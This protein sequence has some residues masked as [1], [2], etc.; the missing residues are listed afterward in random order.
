MAPQKTRT[1]LLTCAAEGADGLRPS[2]PTVVS[3]LTPD[4][5][6]LLSIAGCQSRTL[7][8]KQGQTVRRMDERDERDE[9]DGVSDGEEHLQDPDCPVETFSAGCHGIKSSSCVSEPLAVLVRWSPSGRP[10]PGAL[11]PPDAFG[12]GNLYR[13][14]PWEVTALV[15]RTVVLVEG[16]SDRLALERL[17]ER[18]GCDLEASGVRVVDVGGVTNFRANLVRYGPH[19]EGLR[20]AGLCDEGEG[21]IVLRALQDSGVGGT[22]TLDTMAGAGFFICQGELED[23]LLRAVGI[24]SI[25]RII[26]R[27]GNL[28]RFRSMQRQLA[29]RHAPLEV[30]V[31]HLMTQYK[32]AYAP[33]LIDALDVAAIPRPLTAVLD[34]ALGRSD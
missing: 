29:Y 30:Q 28:R 21:L 24:P 5:K 15:T 32:I 33:L 34:Y 19:G 6:L 16:M 1:R 11:V 9:R 18:L 22:L 27:Q 31:R 26:E 14:R 4:T 10:T 25:L 23:E 12:L 13:D 20:L 8:W 17:A 2:Y 7:E 3:L